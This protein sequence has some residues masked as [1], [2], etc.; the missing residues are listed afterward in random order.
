MC[1]LKK[2]SSGQQKE[3]MSTS[4]MQALPGSQASNTVRKVHS[5]QIFF[6]PF[7]SDRFFEAAFAMATFQV[8]PCWPKTT[9]KV[10]VR[11]PSEILAGLKTRHRKK[12]KQRRLTDLPLQIITGV[13]TWLATCVVW[14]LRLKSR[15]SSRGKECKKKEK[16]HVREKTNP[17][18]TKTCCK[19]KTKPCHC[20]LPTPVT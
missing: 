11:N 7:C 19:N 13:I 6:P 17:E 12:A 9:L 3:A 4:L 2:K 1:D 5:K 10:A 16:S 8:T 15:S 18:G 20:F 14:A